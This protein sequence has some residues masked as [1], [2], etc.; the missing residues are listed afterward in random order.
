MARLARKNTNLVE[1][2]KEINYRFHTITYVSFWSDE[3]IFTDWQNWIIRLCTKPLIIWLNNY[4]GGETFTSNVYKVFTH[5]L[6]NIIISHL[7]GNDIVCESQC[8]FR[9]KSV[10]LKHYSG[11]TMVNMPWGNHLKPVW[12]SLNPSKPLTC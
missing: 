9:K 3:K 7:E 2:L 6:E 5:V 4:W 8:T 12:G 10:N 11:L 1:N